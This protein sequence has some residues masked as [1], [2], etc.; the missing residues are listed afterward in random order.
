M[1]THS[2]ILAWRI[3]WTEEPG[4]LQS[5]GWLW[6]T[7]LQVEKACRGSPWTVLQTLHVELCL[8]AP[9][10]HTPLTLVMCSLGRWLL[11]QR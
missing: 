1:A 2:S 7:H 8:Y 4:G 9:V 3:P 10:T 5:T 11:P 6:G